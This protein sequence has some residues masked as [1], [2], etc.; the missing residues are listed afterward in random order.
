MERLE[1]GTANFFFLSHSLAPTGSCCLVTPEGNGWWKVSDPFVFHPNPLHAPM[2][3]LC[4]AWEVKSVVP[5][6][7]G[8]GSVVQ[9]VN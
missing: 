2:F 9:M 7:F 1:Q 3:F 5:E 6:E 8:D 4:G